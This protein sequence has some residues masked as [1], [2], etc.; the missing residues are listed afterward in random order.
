MIDEVGPKVGVALGVVASVGGWELRG[1][2][3][4]LVGSFFLEGGVKYLEGGE[5][6]LGLGRVLRA[7]IKWR[8][9]LTK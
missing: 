9:G 5:E 1:R 6:G 2:V 3:V 8:R 7:V 4:S